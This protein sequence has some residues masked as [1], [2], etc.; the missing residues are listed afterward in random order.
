VVER[1]RARVCAQERQL[2]A[3]RTNTHARTHLQQ[4]RRNAAPARRRRDGE[5]HDVQQHAAQ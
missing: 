4:R 2:T 1:A 5:A 3:R